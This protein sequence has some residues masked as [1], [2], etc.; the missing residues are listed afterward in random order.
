MDSLLK[1][2]ILYFARAFVTQSLKFGLG[3]PKKTVSE[4]TVFLWLSMFLRERSVEFL[5]QLFV[6]FG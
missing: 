4:E 6:A 1:F 3:S 5:L 2:S